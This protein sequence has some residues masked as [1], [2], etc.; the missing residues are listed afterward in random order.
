MAQTSTDIYLG[1]LS[2]SGGQVR[3]GP[4]INITDR[5]GYDNQPHF[6][7]DG[8]S[9]LYTSIRDDQADTYRYDLALASTERL[10]R[11]D[12]SEYSPTAMTKGGTFSVVQVEAD[13]TQRLWHFDFEGSNRGVLLADVQPVGYHAWI[14][15]TMVALFVLG[16]PPTLQ[17]ADTR[18]GVAETVETGIGRSLHRIPSDNRL[19]FV[20]KLSED[21]WWLKALD[22]NTLAATKLVRTPPAIE[23]YA[24]TPE[25][26]ILMG[27]GSKLLMWSP[28]LDEGWQEVADLA[29]AGLQG[30]TRLAVSPDGKFIA[31]VA[32]AAG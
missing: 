10:T 9:L 20:H 23:D 4:L 19:S 29:A 27:Q 11:T 17:L 7:P 32:Q 5:A 24:W 6:T 30:I 28:R 31:I 2:S 15:S 3:I 22:T 1:A 18:T 12:E 16:D 13:S 25:G 8:R 26:A 14:D 21:E